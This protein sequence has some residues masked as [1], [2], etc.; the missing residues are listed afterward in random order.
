MHKA[1]FPS[2]RL[3]KQ[4]SLQPEFPVI[5]SW[6]LTKFS[7]YW[8]KMNIEDFELLKPVSKGIG[9]INIIG[10]ITIIAWATLSLFL[11]GAYGEV[12]IAKKKTGET[13]YAIKIMEKEHIQRK[14]ILDEI[15]SEKDIM[16]KIQSQFI[17]PDTW[18]KESIVIKVVIRYLLLCGNLCP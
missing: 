1:E 5:S 14:N 8:E 17:V 16:G 10:T 3:I 9:I 13:R 18:V 12:Y 6:F 7:F 11:L 2:S 4:W 15:S